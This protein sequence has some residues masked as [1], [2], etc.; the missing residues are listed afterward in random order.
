MSSQVRVE[1]V[2][3]LNTEVMNLL[4]EYYEALHVVQWDGADVMQQLLGDSRSGMWTAYLEGTPAGCVVLWG[5]RPNDEAG[6]C[7]RLYVRPASR[8]QGIADALMQALENFAEEQGM[9][10]V[11]LDTNEDFRGSVSL[12]RRRGY[13][14]CERYN[15]NPQATM[16][17]R[18][19]LGNMAVGPNAPERMI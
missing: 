18:K 17:Y 11:Y 2:Q 4:E 7:K 10:W 14:A 1:R 6:E 9:H 3:Y 12:Y 5:G 8:R 19:E 15:S 13:A 16:F